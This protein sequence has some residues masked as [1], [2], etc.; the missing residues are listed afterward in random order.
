MINKNF[1]EVKSF[2]I[3]QIICYIRIESKIEL[4]SHS[5][6]FLPQNLKIFR[7]KICYKHYYMLI[8]TSSAF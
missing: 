6:F 3:E 2:I 4:R 5:D 8:S 7:L 1:E